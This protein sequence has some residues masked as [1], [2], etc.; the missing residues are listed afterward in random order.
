[1]RAL[2]PKSVETSIASRKYYYLFIL[3]PIK[4]DLCITGC[5]Q[6]FLICGLVL[7]MCQSTRNE[8]L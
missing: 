6:F 4:C 8:A 1:M 2:L 3:L 5:Y 7:L